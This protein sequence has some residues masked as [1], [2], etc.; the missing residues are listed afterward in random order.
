MAQSRLKKAVILIPL[1]YND[2]TRIPER[3]QAEIY[4]ELFDVYQGW[5]IEGTVKGAYRM[6]T[7]EKRVEQLVRVSI[8][9]AQREVPELEKRVARWGELIGQET[10]LLEVTES[11]IRFVPARRKRRS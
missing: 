3:I 2:G 4:D 1:T 6:R 10:M 9:L 8:V 7:G 11:V 5:T